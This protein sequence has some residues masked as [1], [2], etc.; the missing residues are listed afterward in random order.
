M[1]NGELTKTFREL[2]EAVDLLLKRSGNERSVSG[3][4]G[5]SDVAGFAGNSPTGEM[6]E[7]AVQLIRRA[8]QRLKSL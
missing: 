1:G 5:L 8:L 7:E 3:E 6:N 2:E 4:R